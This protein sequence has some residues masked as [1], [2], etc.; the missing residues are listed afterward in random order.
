MSHN[1]NSSGGFYFDGN[2]GMWFNEEDPN[3][4]LYNPNCVRNLYLDY[5]NG[6]YDYYDDEEEFDDS[7]LDEEYGDYGF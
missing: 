2:D 6:E 1:M 5:V 4:E 7:H 3:D